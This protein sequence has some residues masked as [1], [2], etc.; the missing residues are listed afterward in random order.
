LFLIRDLA[1]KNHVQVVFTAPVTVPFP[2]DKRGC[3]TVLGAGFVDADSFEDF[4]E[5]FTAQRF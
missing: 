3:T 4:S 1:L 2:F 5:L